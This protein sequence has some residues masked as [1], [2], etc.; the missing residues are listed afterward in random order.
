MELVVVVAEVHDLSLVF[1]HCKTDNRRLCYHD[2]DRRLVQG[3]LFLPWLDDE[4]V[5]V[6]TDSVSSTSFWNK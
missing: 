3:A 1:V 5:R 4:V 6:V 2:E